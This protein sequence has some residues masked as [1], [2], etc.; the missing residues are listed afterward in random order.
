MKMDVAT[1]HNSNF[2]NYTITFPEFIHVQ[3]FPVLSYVIKH[4]AMKAYWG[5]EI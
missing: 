3:P 5:V 2:N 4:Y 1:M